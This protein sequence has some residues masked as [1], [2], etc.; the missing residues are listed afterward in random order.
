LALTA[1]DIRRRRKSYSGL[2]RI[3]FE[4]VFRCR[5]SRR[6]TENAGNEMIKSDDNSVQYVNPEGLHKN[7]AYS[8]AIVVSGTAKTVYVGGQNSIDASGAVVGKG[9]LKAQVEQILKNLKIALES[10]GAGPE[11]IVKWNIYVVEGQPIQAGFEAFQRAWG[12]QPHPP[13]ITAVYVA[14]LGNPDFLVEID[15]VAVVP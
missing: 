6:Q 13:V 14:G 4:I 9:D 15:A 11:N 10:S 3:E 8:Q 7:P 1:S 5:P 12:T 2:I